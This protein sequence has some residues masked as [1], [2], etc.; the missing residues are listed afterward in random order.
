[1]DETIEIPKIAIWENISQIVNILLDS[2]DVVDRDI[3]YLILMAKQKMKTDWFQ[4]MI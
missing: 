2:E 4:E 1:M 3:G